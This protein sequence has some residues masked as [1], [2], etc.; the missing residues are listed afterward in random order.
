MY[1]SYLK[2]EK[3]NDLLEEWR[4]SRFVFRSA[5][6][7]LRWRLREFF[8]SVYTSVYVHRCILMS[9]HALFPKFEPV[10]LV[11]EVHLR[12]ISRRVAFAVDRRRFYSTLTT[13]IIFETKRISHGDRTIICTFPLA[14]TYNFIHCFAFAHQATNDYFTREIVIESNK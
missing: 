4:K 12:G 14:S 1:I 5:E 10:L 9:R 13:S 2:T 8:V 3:R 6:T 11:D 7:S